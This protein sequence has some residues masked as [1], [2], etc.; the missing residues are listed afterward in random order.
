[1]AQV[2]LTAAAAIE[3]EA[4]LL[5]VPVFE[6]DM[7]GSLRGVVLD[8]DRKLERHLS[9][10][11]KEERFRGKPDEAL[12]LHTVGRLP[13]AR[14]MLL[15]LG[16][17]AGADAIARAGF[18]PLRMAAGKA[19]RAAASWP[20]RCRASSRRRGPPAPSRRGRSSAR[21]RSSATRAR[22]RRSGRCAP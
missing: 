6:E 11:A 22:S 16:P 14:V 12:Q 9:A 3:V 2:E 15:G 21:T 7:S 1:M 19:A 4:G 10:A 5:A 13:A 17:R 18:E 8:L 20:S